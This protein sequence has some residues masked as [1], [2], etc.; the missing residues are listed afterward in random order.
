MKTKKYIQKKIDQ[1][2]I[3]ND[4]FENIKKNIDI[5]LSFK[6]KNI[7]GLERDFNKFKSYE[8]FINHLNQFKIYKSKREEKKSVKDKE[9]QKV[10]ENNEWFIIIPKTHKASCLYGAHTKWCTTAKKGSELEW[11]FKDYTSLGTLYYIINKKNNRK[12]AIYNG[13]DIEEDRIWENNKWI[14][15]N[16]FEIR[17]E[18]EKIIPYKMI[19]LKELTSDFFKNINSY[20]P[21]KT[22]NFN[23]KWCLTYKHG[24]HYFLNNKP[25]REDGPAF[26]GING[27]KFWYLN[28]EFHR[29]DGPA[30]EYAD[31][32]KYWYLNNKLHREDG[33]ACDHANGTKIWYLNSKKYNFQNYLKKLYKISP[34]KAKYVK[35]KYESEI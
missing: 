7:E 35:E 26:E 29:T 24:K 12:Y 11:A 34:Q 28:G 22:E 5:Y 33:P 32:T 20:C 1:W 19:G 6:N 16:V 25:H 14:V 17:D 13:V 27:A 10:F 21:F 18:K 8:D 3:Q 4:S 2:A 30:V 31:G 15:K 9:I 23:N